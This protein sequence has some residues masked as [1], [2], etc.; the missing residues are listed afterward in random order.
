MRMPMQEGVDLQHYTDGNYAKE[1]LTTVSDILTYMINALRTAPKE[2]DYLRFKE[3]K[4]EQQTLLKVLKQGKTVP[5]LRQKVL[6]Q[7]QVL[8][9]VMKP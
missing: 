7:L 5:A 9:T 6:K 2:Y 1:A 3:L 4:K 8:P